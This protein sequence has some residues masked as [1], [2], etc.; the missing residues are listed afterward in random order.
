M[1]Q[2]IILKS[3]NVI[4]ISNYIEFPYKYRK[5]PE[6]IELQLNIPLKSIYFGVEKVTIAEIEISPFMLYIKILINK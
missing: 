5:I 2:M 3:Y 4:Q 6:I 1:M